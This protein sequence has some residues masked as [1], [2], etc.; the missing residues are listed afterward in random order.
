MAVVRTVESGE[1]EAWAR[2][3]GIGFL[4]PIEEGF[5]TYYLEGTDPARS[6]AAFDGD[7]VVGTLRSFPTTLTV[8]GLAGV[9]ASAFTNVTVAPTHRRQGLLTAMMMAELR[10]SKER[11]EPLG[12]LIASEYPIYGRFGFGPAVDAASYAVDSRTVRFLDPPVGTVELVDLPTLRRE[13]PPVYDHF[14][15][16]RPGSIGRDDRW[17]DRVLLQ[18]PVPGAEPWK[19]YQALY[20]SPEGRFEGFVRYEASEDWDAMRVKGTLKVLDLVGSTPAAEGRLWRYCCEVDLTS[21]VVAR[22]R[23]VDELLPRLLTDARVARQTGRWDFLWVRVLD[24]AEALSAR[25]YPTAGEIVVEVTDDLGLAR[26]HFL[27]EAGPDG[28]A[29]V[30]TNRMADLT[31]SAATLG[32]LYLGGVPL[33]VLLAAGRIVENRPGAAEVAGAMFRSTVPPW[34]NTWF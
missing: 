8:P 16:G 9:T 19:G 23:S 11:G 30:Q 13:G 25:R 7:R 26:G 21:E 4:M 2:Q 34:S 22:D 31:L 15:A 24:V 14:R 20:R 33:A 32:S 28:S 1:A 6:W 5:G 18:V 27:L 3:M 10:A 17:W 12:I 29:C